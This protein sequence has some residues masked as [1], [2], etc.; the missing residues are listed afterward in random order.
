MKGLKK[1]HYT[2]ALGAFLVGFMLVLL[3]KSP[4]V[5]GGQTESSSSLVVVQVELENQQLASDNARLQQELANYYEGL[6]TG[7]LTREQLAKAEMNAG[8]VSVKAPGVRITLDDSSEQITNPE[9]VSKYVIHEA[10]IREIVNILWHGGAEAISINRSRVTGNTE[11]FC[12]GAFIQIN[13]SR[14]MAPYIIEAVGDIVRMQ[15]ALD[16]YYWDELGDYSQKYGIVRKMEIADE[17]MIP[18]ANLPIY[19]YA[20]PGKE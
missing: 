4:S 16:F 11:I 10:Y 14:Q 12:S 2:T 1:A 15:T 20:E 7:T 13:G 8:L 17:L 19:R 6:N 5:T 9:N 3:L 18:S